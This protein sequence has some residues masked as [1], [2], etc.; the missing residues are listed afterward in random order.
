MLFVKFYINLE[1]MNYELLSQLGVRTL[2]S[3]GGAWLRND[4][5]GPD[6]QIVVRTMWRSLVISWG[7]VVALVALIPLAAVANVL[8]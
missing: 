8:M 5:D 3:L 1:R 2:T 4:A 6:V 7:E